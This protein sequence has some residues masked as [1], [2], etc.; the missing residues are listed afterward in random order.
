[1]R[2]PS[3]WHMIEIESAENGYIIRQRTGESGIV[4]TEL[5]V[6]ENSPAAAGTIARVVKDL[7]LGIIPNTEHA[8]PPIGIDH[9]AGPGPTHDAHPSA[10]GRLMN[11]RGN[12][13]L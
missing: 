12:E 5:Y 13:K 3:K 1:M 7:L 8:R 2:D 11:E 6:V 9:A 10:I 4:N